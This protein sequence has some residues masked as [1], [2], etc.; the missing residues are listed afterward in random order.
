MLP[1]VRAL[2]LEARLVIHHVI[3]NL[4]LGG[5]EKLVSQLALFQHRA[6]HTVIVQ[7]LHGAGPLAEALRAGGVEVVVNK[8]PCRLG[9]AWNLMRQFAARPRGVVHCHNLMA[10]LLG[11]P[12]ARLARARVVL[13]TRHGQA[14]CNRHADSRF[15]FIARFCDAVVAVSEASRRSLARSAG[16]TAR[17]MVTIYN[18]AEPGST[19]PEGDGKARQLRG[20]FVLISVGRLVA[21]KDFPTLLQAALLARRRVPDLRLWILGRGAEQVRL[22]QLIEELGLAGTVLLAGA[23]PDVGS[24]LA[25][26]DLFVLSSISEGLP[27]ALLESM[28]AGLACVVTDAG[29]MPEVVELAGSGLVVSQRDPE[30]LAARIV[31]LA[32]DAERRNRLAESARRAYQTHFSIETMARRYEELYLHFDPSL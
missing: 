2:V 32:E 21:E 31:E 24:W 27:I 12:A 15:W 26:A 18:G 5:A 22:E 8:A 13:D 4:E 1:E 11:G 30:T 6:G 7:C 17:K 20:S 14:S 28:A 9:V 19:S 23:R 25:A 10:L 16:R 3:D 29:G